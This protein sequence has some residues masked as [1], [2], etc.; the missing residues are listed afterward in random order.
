MVNINKFSNIFHV[1]DKNV[2]FE[3]VSN[4]EF[5]NVKIKN[6]NYLFI[7]QKVIEKLAEKAFFQI[8]HFASIF[9]QILTN[10]WKPRP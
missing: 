7:D 4:A 2:L 3:K 10:Y 1:N 8:S 6:R 5:E 9:S